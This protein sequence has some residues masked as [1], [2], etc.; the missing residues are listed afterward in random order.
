ML[1]NKLVDNPFSFVIARIS[2]LGT[3]I[4]R[5]QL[6]SSEVESLSQWLLG[7][8]IVTEFDG[9]YTSA[10]IVETEAYK[11]PEDKASHAYGNRRTRRTEIMFGTAGRAYVYLCYGIH[12]LFNI[13]TGPEERAHAILVRAV[14]PLE[15]LE[16]MLSRRN[17]NKVQRNLTAGPGLLTQALGI[18]TMHSGLDITDTDS[19]VRIEDQGV[20]IPHQDILKSPRVGVSYAAEWAAK[21]WR[22]RIKNNLWTSPA[23]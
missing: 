1:N 2:F 19:P 22:F 13:V 18:K 21:P 16:H 5:Q 7:K 6:E 20:E 23:K 11:A 8:T 15:G 3:I 17:L 10:K 9:K 4:K 12:H 14:E